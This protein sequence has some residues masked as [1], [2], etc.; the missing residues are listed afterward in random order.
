MQVDAHVAVT[1]GGGVAA[2]PHALLRRQET[3]GRACVGGLYESIRVA[4][5]A[6]RHDVTDD[7]LYARGSLEVLHSVNAAV[8]RRDVEVIDGVVSHDVTAAIQ[9]KSRF[10][11]RGPCRGE[12]LVLALFIQTR[13][14]RYGSGSIERADFNDGRAHWEDMRAKRGDDDDADDADD[15]NDAGD[16]YDHDDG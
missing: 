1:F 15:A 10:L 9:R 14:Q 11:I 5:V 4:L 7:E 12:A 13:T 16:G 2:A 6:Q 3:L 8:T